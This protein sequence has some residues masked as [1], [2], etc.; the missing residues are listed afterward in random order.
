MFILQ[1]GAVLS[2][3]SLKP[4]IE[5]VKAIHEMKLP[6]TP[7]GV[8][9]FLGMEGYYRKFINQFADAARPL[10]KL[11]RKYCK[12]NWAE[13]CQ[14]GFEYLR[15][16][17]TQSPILKYPD[18]NKCYVVF[19]DASDQAAA[20]VL[21]QEYLDDNGQNKEMPIAYLSAQFS[22]SQFKWSTVVIEGFAIYI[23]IKKW[24][25]YLEDAE[26]LLK[27]DAK[28]LQKFLNGKTDNLKLDRWSLELQGRN[29]Q[30]EH[31]PGYKNKA[32]NCLSQLPFVT[33][34]RNDNPLK[35]LEVTVNVTQAKEDT[36]CSPLCEVD[37]TDT[38]TLQQEDKH[39]IRIAK[40]LND[41][42]T[43]FHERDSYGYDDKGILYHINRQNGREYKATVVP[44]VL[45][46]T[47]LREMHDNFGHFGIGNTYSMIN[48]NMELCHHEP[49]PTLIW[50]VN[51]E[52]LIP[53]ILPWGPKSMKV[54]PLN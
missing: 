11:T 20:A 18:P 38:K 23:A 22:D 12:F 1:E 9:E 4:Q 43:R 10:T 2:W 44:K 3:P 15:T 30:I 34:K 53:A 13:E 52:F 46:Q 40:L 7:K 5:K 24:R 35:D 14:I 27:S 33:R 45:V 42:K 39:C 19:T 16:C 51:F 31:I 32:V 36:S 37:L 41:P 50:S 17:L 49:L 47:I 8:R 26:I 21:T 48:P 25:H 29:I 6:K 54:V 28:L